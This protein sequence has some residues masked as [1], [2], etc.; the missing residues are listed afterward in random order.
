MSPL[1]ECL[2]S[3]SDNPRMKGVCNK[4]GRVLPPTPER[5]R[6]FELETLDLAVELCERVHSVTPRPFVRTVFARL[7]K[8]G[9]D[10]AGSWSSRP[11]RELLQEASE[12][13]ADAVAWVL[14][15]MQRL[16]AELPEESHADALMIALDAMAYCA[17]ADDALR[18][19]GQL[20][21][22]LGRP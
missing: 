14:L 22:E 13:P 8:G 6:E 11:E 12:E 17:A 1:A 19:L 9:A 3:E 5:D 18:R 16:R 7:V 4:C 20:A 10:Y 15:Y 2:H 21:D